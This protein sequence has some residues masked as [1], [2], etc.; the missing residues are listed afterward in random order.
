LPTA[1][2]PAARLPD[3]QGLT[4]R[5]AVGRIPTLYSRRSA[6]ESDQ[7]MAPPTGH[8]SLTKVYAIIEDGPHQYQVAE[9]DRLDVQ[10]HDVADGQSTVEFEKVL[11]VRDGDDLKIGQPYLPG[12]KVTAKIEGEVKGEKIKIHKYRRRKASRTR[13]GHRQRYLRVKIDKIET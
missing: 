13:M 1:V 12:A 7:S 10:L 11:F 8:R 4:R 9:G 6:S 5:T 2:D 3:P